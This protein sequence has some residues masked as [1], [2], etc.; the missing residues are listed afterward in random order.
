M[1]GKRLPLSTS[2]PTGE[3]QRKSGRSRGDGRALVLQMTY[4]HFY[5]VA[6][7]ACSGSRLRSNE[8]WRVSSP[9]KYLPH[10]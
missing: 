4:D 2:H 1:E 6:K 9:H 10:D 5:S 3:D 8:L 7:W